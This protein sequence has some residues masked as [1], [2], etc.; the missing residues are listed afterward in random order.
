[1]RHL[2]PPSIKAVQDIVSGLKDK[3]VAKEEIAKR[4]CMAV[5]Q[6]IGFPDISLILLNPTDGTPLLTYSTLDPHWLISVEER[7][8][9]HRQAL[10]SPPQKAEDAIYHITNR[11]SLHF[12]NKAQLQE[13]VAR[14][15][16]ECTDGLYLS[17]FSED[18]VILGMGFIHGW[19]YHIRLH[20]DPLF[21]ERRT[22]LPLVIQGASNALDNLLIHQRIETLLSDRRELKERIQRDEEDLKR[23]LLELTVLYDTSNTLGYSLNYTQIVGIVMD[24]LSKVLHFDICTIFLLDFVPGGETITRMSRD[25]SPE[26]I[27]SAQS[28]IVAATTPFVKRVLDPDAMRSTVTKA[29]IPQV[30]TNEPLVIRSFANVPLIFKEEVI[31]MLNVCSTLRNAFTR[32]EMTFLHTMANQLSANLGRL[33]IIKRLEKSKMD[34]VIRSMTDGVIMMDE[35]DRLEIINPAAQDML[36]LKYPSTENVLERLE[37]IKLKELYWETSRTN[38]PALEQEISYKSAYFSV[39]IVPVFDSEENR[40]GTVLVFR[41]FTELHKMNKI[42]TQRLE[43]ISKV[44]LIL[45]SITDLD[46]LLSLLMEFILTVAN[47][48]MGAIQLLTGRNF[49]TRVHSNF[50]D[51][52]RREYKFISGETLSEYTAKTRNLCLIEN[53]LHNP[54]VNHQVKILIDSYVCIPILA[55]DQIIGLLNIARRYGTDQPGWSKDDLKTLTT[56]TNLSGTAIHNAVLYQETLKKQKLDQELKIANEIQTKL[57]PEAIPEIDGA[58]IGA[59]SVPAREIGGDYYDFFE[60]EDGRVGICIADIVGKGIPAGLYMAMLKSILHTHLLTIGSPKEALEKINLLLFRDPVIQKFV[61]LFYGILDP[62]TQTFTYANAGHEPAVIFRDGHVMQLDTE[63]F[64]LGALPESYYEEKT[65]ALKEGDLLMLFTDGFIESRNAAGLRFDITQLHL[66]V[67]Q[68]EGLSSPAFV[69]KVYTQLKTH[70]D[71]AEAS[72][73][74]TVVAVR[75]HNEATTREELPLRVKKIRVTSTK[76]F[77][78]RIRQETESIAREMGFSEEDI[79]NLK[80]AI[81]EAQSNVIEHAYF[82]SEKGDILFEFRVFRDRL[83]VIIKDFGPGMG[84]KTI[85][86]E[87]H[88]D[89]LEG[90]GL[91]VFLI[92]TMMDAVKYNRTSKVGTELCLTKYLKK[93]A[94]HGNH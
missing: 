2:V 63:G 61:P 38:T 64:P 3:V 94:T 46:G 45:K 72:D 20:D 33:K 22:L 12:V 23:R 58:S 42:N 81:N 80:L 87:E 79:F 37:Q 66:L 62:K 92:N 16:F 67:S 24:A 65:I 36:R 68:S 60:L 74:V 75:I 19:Q 53:Y 26:F 17:L 6:G 48:E 44:D 7:E 89:E 88:L 78:K 5:T 56:I 9:L 8:W 54:R 32:N 43:V 21:E 55:K 10:I 35:A 69:D 82:G 51:K 31:G 47:A 25:I 84:S 76:K 59:I 41:D 39:N 93:G 70:L 73:D 28:N 34:A 30:E 11:D 4:F 27:K 91:G 86:G 83:E 14:F 13:D 18:G 50:P 71:P 15:H 49:H 57:L 52:I 77:V 85:K 1:M 90:S 29:P 40:M